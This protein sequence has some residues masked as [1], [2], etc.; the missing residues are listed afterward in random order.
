M[1]ES[2]AYYPPETRVMPLTLLR[3]ER[4]LPVPGTV[5]AQPGQ[6]VEPSDV[7][8][9]VELGGQFRT[10]EIARLLRVPPARAR[11]YLRKQVGDVI[12]AG[13][14]IAGRSGLGGRPVRSPV[15]GMLVEIDERNGRVAIEM[16]SKLI[17]LRAYL[18]GVIGN[19]LGGHGVVVES[20]G[21]LIQAAWGIGGESYGVLRVVAESANEPL[22]ASAIDIKM[23]GSVVAGGG[24]ITASALEQAQQ[25]QLRGMI[26]GS[27]EGELIDAALNMPFPIIL[28]EGV[29]R[30]PMAA[31][32]FELIQSQEG[33]EVSISAET[34]TRWG[35]LR[36][37]ILIPLPADTRPPMPP[38][39]GSP[40][41]V[42]ARVRVVRGPQVGWVGTVAAIPPRAQRI[43]IG[44]RVHGAEVRFGP[45]STAF[46]PFANLELLR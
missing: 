35:V 39:V 10:F 37:E 38:A 25:L 43:E 29:G 30:V 44:T 16:T 7:V 24:W 27:I 26:A 9:Q 45:G 6:R 18:K 20:P 13:D 14:V 3:R 40:L 36:P 11:R 46:V 1:T 15:A 23:H 8:A 31:P 17:E 12:K 4:M 2:T 41:T 19:V 33:R 22:R 21:A 32:I 5:L 34:R 28:T 42:G